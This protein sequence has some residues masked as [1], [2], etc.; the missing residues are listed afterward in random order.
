MQLSSLVAA[1]AAVSY[2]HLLCVRVGV[3]KAA[4]AFAL[5]FIALDHS[6]VFFGMSGMETQLATALLLASAYYVYLRSWRAAGVT[7]GLT[8]LAR[9]DFLLWV[10]AVALVALAWDGAFFRVA[11]YTTLVYGPWLVLATVYFGSPVPHTIVAKSFY[12]SA[13]AHHSAGQVLESYL[14]SW[15]TVLAPF[16]DFWFTVHTPVPV[17]VLEGAAALFLL[18]ILVGSVAAGQRFRGLLPVVAYLVLFFVYRSALGL[19]SYF[20]WYLPPVTA[21]GAVL[22]AVGIDRT[23]LRLPRVTEV[24]AAAMAA[25]FA[26]TVPWMM[27]LDRTTRGSAGR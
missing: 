20:M 8:L 18:F 12:E 23:R 19:S 7:C 4:E 1:V 5:A 11:G 24:A 16:K 21:L 26:I 15:W 22:P 6:Q 10:A 25:L 2:A 9:P 3:S 17:G 14:A 13:V 27:P